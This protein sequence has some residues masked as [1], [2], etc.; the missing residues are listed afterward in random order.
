MGLNREFRIRIVFEILL[1]SVR[2][3]GER[4]LLAADETDLRMPLVGI[5]GG[6]EHALERD[7]GNRLDA[8]DDVNGGRLGG[9][10]AANVRRIQIVGLVFVDG[11]SRLALGTCDVSI[12]SGFTIWLPLGST[13]LLSSVT[14]SA[15]WVCHVSV[16][17]PA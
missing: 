7:R 5:V 6:I 8:A 2:E 1:E 10:A 17:D 9:A 16:D 4:K 13:L 14:L 15:L 11:A 3:S 12:G